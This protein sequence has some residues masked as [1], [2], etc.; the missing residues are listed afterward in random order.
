MNTQKKNK[1][2]TSRL[3]SKFASKHKWKSPACELLSS[4]EQEVLKVCKCMPGVGL[5][6]Q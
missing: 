1:S 2:I 5:H 3:N 4:D 6:T